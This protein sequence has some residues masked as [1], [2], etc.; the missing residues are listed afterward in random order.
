M[1]LLTLEWADGPKLQAVRA[2]LDG[3]ANVNEAADD[4]KTVLMSAAAA[5]ADPE[6]VA[7][8]VSKGANARATDAAGR[9][10]LHHLVLSNRNGAATAY[11][12]A[13]LAAGADPRVADAK[14]KSPIAEAKAL[15]AKAAPILKIFEGW[16]PPPPSAEALQ[17]VRQLPIYAAWLAAVM[18]A[19]DKAFDGDADVVELVGLVG[20]DDEVASHREMAALMADLEEAYKAGKMGGGSYRQL[21]AARIAHA[22]VA[23]KLSKLEDDSHAVVVWCAA[24]KRDGVAKKL[25]KYNEKS[26]DRIGV[27]WAD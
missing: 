19:I 1:S 17:A 11:A 20:D 9:T 5:C 18:K 2:A 16:T 13:L 6:V 10:A 4:G 12:S 24:P 25:A 3:G 23:S 21:S 7:F 22:A 27:A 15:K 8:L 14:G 26:G